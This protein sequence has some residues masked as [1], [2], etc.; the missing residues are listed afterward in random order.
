M[1]DAFSLYRRQA[2][3]LWTIV[4]I[5]I[6]PA[7][8]AVWVIIRL[9]LSGGTTFAHNGTIYTSDST[10]PTTISLI[11]FGFV[12]AVLCVGALSRLLLDSYTGHRTT[13]R[14][15][16]AYS[17]ER[18]GPL[19][20][21]ALISGLLIGIGFVLIVVPGVYL[22]VAWIV[23]VPVLM[24]EGTGSIEALR[25]S[26]ELISDHWWT[27]FAALLLGLICIIGV[28]ILAGA[29][30]GAVAKSGSVDV[31][32]TLSCL[33]R[34]IGA[35]ISYPILAAICAVLYAELRGQREHIGAHDMTG[36]DTPPESQEPAPHMPDIGLS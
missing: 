11:V 20:W 22:L 24:F 3:S 26:R 32:L 31:V 18:L 9:S 29:I 1:R 27:A 21:L 28:S 17:A 4:A 19:I 25:R 23:S 34:I 7:Q 12:A 30:L 5:I 35:L 2:M 8:V 33:S 14:R 16:L 13:W 36:V 10:A 6:V 15:S